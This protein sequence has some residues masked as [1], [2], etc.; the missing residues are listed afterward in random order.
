LRSPSREGRP[1]QEIKKNHPALPLALK[2]TLDPVRYRVKY[3]IHILD[4]LVVRKAE[5]GESERLQPLLPLHIRCEL[6][7]VVTPTIYFDDQTNM[8]RIKIH[9]VAIDGLLAKEPNAKN[10]APPK[11]GPKQA[12]RI[13]HG[14][15]KLPGER[16]E[17]RPVGDD[18]P[19]RHRR[20]DW[21][22][23]PST[24]T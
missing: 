12:L 8:L 4:D 17:V 20:P 19:A 13:G 23:L 10:L 6:F 5:D 18:S 1:M 16:L 11:G 14:C 3:G 21:T 7:G 22:L 15:P 9:D 2:M 24:R